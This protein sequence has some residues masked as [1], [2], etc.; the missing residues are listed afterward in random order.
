MI[1]DLR[2]Y[3]MYGGEAAASLKMYEQYGL[4]V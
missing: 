4:P 3:T 2:I 1:F